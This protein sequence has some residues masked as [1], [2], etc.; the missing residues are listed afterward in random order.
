VQ[1]Y[2]QCGDD[3]NCEYTS[4]E[5]GDN[6]CSYTCDGNSTTSSTCVQ[7][8]YSDVCEDFEYDDECMQFFEYYLDNESGDAAKNKPKYNPN[9]VKRGLPFLFTVILLTAI[10]ARFVHKR[11]SFY[12]GLLRRDPSFVIVV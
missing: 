7:L 4:C 8:S 10:I 5:V 3:E 2:R 6:G 12:C 9:I 11:V 1:R